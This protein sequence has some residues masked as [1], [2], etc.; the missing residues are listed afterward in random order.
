MELPGVGEYTNSALLSFAYGEKVITVDTNVKRIL[1]R[2][3]K[4]DNIN[5]FIERNQ[6]TY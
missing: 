6:K 3:F 5:E 2:Y 1:E 4:K